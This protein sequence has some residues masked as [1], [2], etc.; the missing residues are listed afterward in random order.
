MEHKPD[1]PFEKPTMTVRFE[2]DMLFVPSGFIAE[3]PN[4]RR[5][6]G[7]VLLIEDHPPRVVKEENDGL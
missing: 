7:P 3:L 2:R 4:G 1:G 5:I 6:E